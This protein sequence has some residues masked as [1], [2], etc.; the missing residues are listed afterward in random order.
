MK[1]WNA[2]I[3][4]FGVDHQLWKFEV[5]IFSVIFD[6]RLFPESSSKYIE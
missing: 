4:V 6:D 1:H 2:D 3:T 5:E